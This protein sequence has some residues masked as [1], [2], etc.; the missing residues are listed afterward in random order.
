MRSNVLRSLL[1]ALFSTVL[2]AGIAAAQNPPAN[3]E[4]AQ[5]QPA[6]RD[7]GTSLKDLKK[8]KKSAPEAPKEMTPEEKKAYED[9]VAAAEK[10]RNELEEHIKYVDYTKSE[11]YKKQYEQPFFDTYKESRETVALLKVTDPTTGEIRQAK[12][13]DFDAIVAITDINER[14]DKIEELFGTGIKAQQVLAASEKTLA[15]WKAKE[16]ALA[17][18][19]TKSGEMEKAR[20]EARTKESGE[21]LKAFKETTAEGVTKYPHLFAPADG[22]DK[23]NAAL[24][25]GF[26]LAKLAFGAI[27]ATDAAKLPQWVQERMVNG[28]LPPV[29]MAKLHAAIVNKA[30]AFDRVRFQNKQLAKQIKDLQAKLDGFKSSQPGNGQETAPNRE[31][32]G[33]ASFSDIDKAFDALAAGNR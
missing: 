28:K 10:R 32:S 4:P 17:T 26:A 21:I 22:D 8:T 31:A 29:E 33:N 20:M 24:E 3:D 6:A 23:G 18:Y 5:N 9:K 16:N 15:A 14:A 25:S 30:G 1:V 27:E 12:P 2:V 7:E 11:E 19:K 13:E